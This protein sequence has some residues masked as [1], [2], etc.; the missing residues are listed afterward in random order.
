[1]REELECRGRTDN[2]YAEGDPRVCDGEIS[3][4]ARGK[5]SLCRKK[6]E[7]ARVG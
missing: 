3:E 7:G 1:M 2:G 4:S 5:N 6:N